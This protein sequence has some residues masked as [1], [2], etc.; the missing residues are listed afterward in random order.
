MIDEAVILYYARRLDKILS[1][2]GFSVNLGFWKFGLLTT[3]TLQ[4]GFI[5]FEAKSQ[6]KGVFKI[7]AAF[8]F[9][10]IMIEFVYPTKPELFPD[11]EQPEAT[12]PT[13]EGS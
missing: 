11:P 4:F 6:Y 13:G 12:S 9:I 3:T 1:T 2:I 7:S 8:I 5:F 10:H